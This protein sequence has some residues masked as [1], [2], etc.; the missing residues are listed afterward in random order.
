[1]KKLS[2]DEIQGLERYEQSRAAF[3]SRI[4]AL[5]KNRRVGVGDRVTFVFENRDTML[6]QVQEMLRA[7]HTV[8]I[9]KVR[10]ELEAYNA[11]IPERH[12][13]SAT[14]FI[15]ITDASDVAAELVRLIGIDECVRLQVAEDVS[16]T[17]RFEPGRSTTE[18]LSAVQ[19]VRFELGE[20]GS[21]LFQAAAT[22]ARLVIDHP[23]YRHAA[24][25]PAEV[26]QSLAQDLSAP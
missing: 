2:L 1:M 7:E 5:K 24:T 11:L 23:N 9:D 19:Y 16:L 26:Q 14:M 25:L 4:I 3:R 8:D 18:K 20:R 22:P 15:E 21:A 13:L 12:E 10:E 6:F 17:A